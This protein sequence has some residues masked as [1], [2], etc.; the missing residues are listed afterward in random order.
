M[1]E[2]VATFTQAQARIEQTVEFTIQLRY[3]DVDNCSI[4][5]V[6]KERRKV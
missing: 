2:R 4:S 6:S 1:N 5:A 3:Q